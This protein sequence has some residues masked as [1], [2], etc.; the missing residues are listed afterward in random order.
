[1]SVNFTF[2][3]LISIC[4][5]ATWLI[6]KVL[7]GT[8]DLA[9]AL[10]GMLWACRFVFNAGVTDNNNH[11]P[12][13]NG[14][15][16]REPTMRILLKMSASVAIMTAA[17]M[18]SAQAASLTTLGDVYQAAS[19]T[20]GTLKASSR[21]NAVQSESYLKTTGTYTD[22]VY[23]PSAAQ[24][25][26]TVVIRTP[27]L[28]AP[29]FGAFCSG[30]VIS[31]THILTAA[32]C[33]DEAFGSGDLG[34]PSVRFGGSNVAT[35]NRQNASEV[36]VHPLWFDP[37]LGSAGRGAFGAGDIAIVKLS[38]PLP[39]GTKI[40]GLFE[41]DPLA[42][43]ATH[44]SY[45]TTGNGSGVGGDVFSADNLANGRIGTNKY[46]ITL[47]GLFGAGTGT[48]GQLLYD[49]DNGL[50]ANNG[51]DFW[52][53]GLTLNP[54]N[55][56]K[57]TPG[58]GLDVAPALR[59]LIDDLGTGITEVLIDGGDSGGGAFIGDLVAGVHSFGLTLGGEYCD[60]ILNPNPDDPY[61]TAGAF[62]PEIIPVSDVDCTLNSTFGEI[63]GD[64][65]V[66]YYS[67][68]IKAILGGQTS[69]AVILP[70]PATFG[71]MGLGLLGIAC[72]RRRRPA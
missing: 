16:N 26:G 39:V 44:I 61:D 13:A 5:V 53:S 11:H 42:Q 14:P 67:S 50:A 47:Q 25:S 30:T 10:L 46:E 27:I 34:V 28:S 57:W 60:G 24:R 70:E 63:A 21:P 52:L 59:S 51:F 7:S 18:M 29:G 6:F 72:A 37:V 3:L 71:L 40:Y 19:Y 33:V 48:N 8:W 35:D 69:S 55:S 23:L 54:D 66:S 58:L 45:G 9:Q 36:Y 64:T 32:H 22:P 1:M 17:A 56:L 41:G 65:S 38:S 20:T 4:C 15:G 49:F 12:G 68:W 43:V 2:Y 31:P 62:N